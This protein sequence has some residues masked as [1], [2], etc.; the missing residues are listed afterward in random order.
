MAGG[1]WRWEKATERG[2]RYYEVR[3]DRDLWGQWVL[4]QRWGRRG[5]ALGQT[6]RRP[7]D[8]YPAARSQLEKINQRRLQRGYHPVSSHRPDQQEGNLWRP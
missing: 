1:R 6:R 3:I 7:Y 8:A 4:L 2:V 5:T